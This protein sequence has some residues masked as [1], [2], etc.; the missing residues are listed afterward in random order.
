[1]KKNW[2]SAGA[3][4]VVLLAG[5]GGG[6]AQAQTAADNTATPPVS[7]DTAQSD[8]PAASVTSQSEDDI[9]VTAQRRPEQLID[10]PLSV[11]VL[12]PQR[13]EAAGIKSTMELAA[14]TPGLTI[15][16]LGA[17]SEPLLRGVSTT[18]SG[19]SN[20]SN[21][22][23]YIDG[24]YV[25]AQDSY[26]FDFVDVDQIQ[27]LKGP[28]GTLYGR[29]ATGSAILVT[30]KRPSFEWSAKGS[31]SY[32]NFNTSRGQLY[33]SG[34]ISDTVAFSAAGQFR[35]SDGYIT[36]ITT[37]NKKAGKNHRE[38]IR[39]K[40]L[41]Q[42]NDTMRFTLSA[43]HINLREPWEVNM[44]FD[45]RYSMN[46]DIANRRYTRKIAMTSHLTLGRTTL[47]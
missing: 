18:I 1:M 46:Y 38:T 20:P 30:T 13:L 32:G 23:L 14:V 27:V 2:M 16:T 17:F 7:S 28:Q 29:N 43:D 44:T 21:I 40:L 9:V 39:G 19:V 10:I 24:V 11:A 6:T 37:G 33:L 4:A 41:F 45:P 35:N 25:T 12:T 8:A 15:Q 42:P 22:A 34:P 3:S 31:L 36:N 26:D 47:S 5:I